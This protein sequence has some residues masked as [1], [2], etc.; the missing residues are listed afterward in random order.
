M[1]LRG[2]NDWLASDVDVAWLKPQLNVSKDIYIEQ[3]EHL[4]LIW[5]FDAPTR[6][7]KYIVDEIFPH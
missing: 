1:L 3:Y 5:A 6:V 2:G 7:Y 4:D